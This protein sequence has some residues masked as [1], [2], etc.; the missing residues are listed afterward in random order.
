MTV[1]SRP[2]F[3]QVCESASAATSVPS[4][5]ARAQITCSGLTPDQWQ[6][7]PDQ[8]PSPY[9][10]VAASSIGTGST[11]MGTTSTS[12]TGTTTT[13]GTGT[14]STGGSLLS[15]YSTRIGGQSTT[16]GTAV[17]PAPAPDLYGGTSLDQASALSSGNGA[18]LY[19]CATTGL[20]G[21]V[22]G[23]RTM[24]NVIGMTGSGG[25]LDALGRYI[26]A[27][28]LNAR[29]GRTPVLDE[30]GVRNMWNDLVHRGYFEP[31]AGVRW[32]APQIV[33]YLKTTMG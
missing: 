12:G 16:L 1:A 18:T 13:S 6:A 3:G 20:G 23:S 14:T 10:A 26:V 8:W 9:I 7:I 27:A 28:L 19:H 11:S 5:G 21:R 24:M 29:T 15:Q 31:T 4:S 30:G 25:N 2:V 33:A 22:F 17:T 32:G